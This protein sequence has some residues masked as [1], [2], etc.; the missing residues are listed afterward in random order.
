MKQHVLLRVLSAEADKDALR[1]IL[2]A[3]K[4]KGLRISDAEGSLK[5]GEMLLAV[6]SGHFYAD[7]EKQKTLLEALS[8]GAENVLP[9]K[10]DE[11]EIPEALMN[12][13]YARNIIMA[14]DRD[15]SLIAERILAAVPEKKSALPKVLIAGAAVLVALA[16]LWI[17][18][19]SAPEAEPIPTP[20]LTPEEE[21]VEIPVTLGLTEQDLAEITQ[22]VVAGDYF[23]FATDQMRADGEG[24]DRVY[25]AREEDGEHWYSKEDGREYSLTRYDDLRFLALMPKLRDL[26]IALVEV[27]PE[28]LPNLSGLLKNGSVRLSGCPINSLSWLAGAELERFV[29]D[30]CAVT[31]YSPLTECTRLQEAEIDLTG[32][33]EADFSGFAPPALRE[34]ITNNG[35]L[36]RNPDLSALSGSKNLRSLYIDHLPLTELSFLQEVPSLESL[37]LDDCNDLRDIAGVGTLKKLKK[38]E[39]LYCERITDYTPIAGCTELE[40]IR[41]QCDF[42]P[43]ALR[44]ASFLADLPKL[45]DIGLYSCNL[46]NMNFLEGIAQ[47]QQHI[48][49]GFCGEIPD[50]SGLAY[51]KHYDYLHINPRRNQNVS[52]GPGFRGGEVSAV[53]PYIQDVQVDHLEL[54]EC[55]GTDLSMLPNGIRDL[56]IMY[57]D[58]EDLSGLKSYSLQRLELRDCQYLQ[59]LNGIESIPTMFSDRAQVEIEILGCPRLTDW[60][61][62]D[63]AYLDNLKLVGTYTLPDLGSFRTNVLRLESTD[64]LTDLHCLDALDDSER[65]NLE[66]VGLDALYDLTPLRRL[67]GDKLTVPPQVAEQAEELVVDGLFGEYDIAYPDSG[68]RPYEGNVELLSLE[69]LETLP[70]AMLRRIERLCILGNRV[71]NGQSGWIEED[72]ENGRPVPYWF[73]PETEERT[74]LE[75]GGITNLGIF[76]ELTG[77]RELDLLCEPLESLDGIQNLSALE[78]LNIHYCPNLRDVSAAFALQDLRELD[79]SRNPVESIQGVQN[80]NRLQHL[81]LAAT[82][83]SDLSPLQDCDFSEAYENDNLWLWLSNIPAEDFAALSGIRKLQSI[84]MNGLNAAL[85]VPALENTEIIS[86]WV[87][88][89]FRENESFAAFISAHPEIEQLS[90]PWNQ[91]VTDLTPVLTLPNL[92]RLVVSVDMET[93][94]EPVMAANPGFEI[95]IQN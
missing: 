87:S 82:D 11:A 95:E 52:M 43:D 22:V 58:L 54:Y 93:A 41:F 56:N 13:L 34:L 91:A 16:G 59:S 9:L 42:N 19:S 37:V 73:S 31:D 3:L 72:W 2:D 36:L 17:W 60:S 23:G 35:E 77:L 86:L 6:L 47:N 67:R 18:R 32:Q 89:G 66:L 21:Q 55:G 92:Q 8:A 7:G 63:G 94:L 5:K 57:G 64:G 70:K 61:A 81:N 68:W 76:A 25:A 10:L 30:G 1:P 84:D 12:A 62:L 48:G 90:V 27:D 51:I 26:E 80:L 39:I 85:W 45:H 88:D 79:I 71:D 38:L 46:Y 33:T 49:L 29:I 69:E 28:G 24:A 50:Y 83:I 65:Y 20:E 14:A 44:D 74:A 78:K 53:L 15:A 4:E 75:M 40:N